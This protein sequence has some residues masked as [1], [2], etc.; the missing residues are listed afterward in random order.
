MAV[1]L[2]LTV[3]AP[4][5]GASSGA[6]RLLGL[7]LFLPVPLVLWLLT[8]QPLGTLASL[9]IGF[10]LMATHRLYARPGEA[11]TWPRPLPSS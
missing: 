3:T 1:D 2:T 11:P 10:A 5:G 7:L 4:A 9:A 8:R 6:D